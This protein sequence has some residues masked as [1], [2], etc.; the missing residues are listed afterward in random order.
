MPFC[1]ECR[2]E[3]QTDWVTCPY[4]SA[5]TGGIPS[6]SS[7]IRFTGTVPKQII[8][9]KE[10]DK[11]LWNFV[12]I[13]VTL[14]ILLWPQGIFG[15]SLIERATANCSALDTEWFNLELECSI[16]RF[17]GQ[18]IVFIIICAALLSLAWI[19]YDDKSKPLNIKSRDSEIINKRSNEYFGAEDGYKGSVVIPK[20]ERETP[21]YQTED[22]VLT[23][24]DIKFQ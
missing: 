7:R 24:D 10:R 6:N 9:K 3:V 1:R 4:C 15:I 11:A 20:E 2:K 21:Y 12:I 14:G 17:E 8:V 5:S 22:I 23:S 16:W 18:I 19:N 13:V